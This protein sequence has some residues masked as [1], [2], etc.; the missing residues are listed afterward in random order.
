MPLSVFYDK[1]TVFFFSLQAMLCACIWRVSVVIP[2]RLS[3]LS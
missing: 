3:V 2:E 1:L